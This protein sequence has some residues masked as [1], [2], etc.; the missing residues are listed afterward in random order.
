MEGVIQAATR[1]QFAARE[2]VLEEAVREAVRAGAEQVVE[3]DEGYGGVRTRYVI[4]AAPKGPP[5]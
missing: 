1:V 4:P 5:A 2:R 3:F